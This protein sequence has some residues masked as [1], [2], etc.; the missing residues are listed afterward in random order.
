MISSGVTDCTLFLI[1]DE[2]A[3]LDLLETILEDDGYHAIVRTADARQAIPVFESSAPDLVLLDLH[4]PHRSGFEV[5]RDICERTPPGDYLPVLVLTADV[6][7]QAKERALSGGARDFLTKPFDAGE[8][9]LRVRNLLQTRLL[10]RQQ[11]E[12]REAAEAM[13]AEN[14]LLFAQAQ[15][16]TRARER[17]LSVVAHDLRNPLA[18]VTMYV[19]ML[20]S[21]LPPGE[22]PYRRDALASIFD[23]TQRMQ[24]LIEDLL[25]SARVQEGT[26]ALDREE[27]PVG[28]LLEE[29]ER[30]LRPLAEASAIEL[31]F[32]AD[33][34]PL[35]QAVSLDGA[36]LLQV[37]SNLVGNALKFTP[38]G[39][40]VTVSW[41]LAEGE[42][43]VSV[44]DTGPGIAAEQLP[45]LFG[46][47][48]Q[49]GE[50][51]RRGLGLGLWISRAIVE[52][53]GGRIWVDSREGEGAVFH[54]TLPAAGAGATEELPRAVMAALPAAAWVG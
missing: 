1:D 45:H 53:H 6:T 18:V 31:T 48:W 2:E 11:R 54:F 41:A 14:A 27:Q 9:S 4:M 51:D 7:P 28:R 25:D 38:E 21:M 29:A 30:M 10:Q 34:V 5:L 26:F 42:L 13:A 40:R 19:E 17:M 43:R 47:F 37:I 20:L 12:A 23:S 52:A 8:V 44:A 49:A 16:A 46:A 3:N 39:G 22:D 24:Q 32:R 50:A 36:R 35:A 15:D 33:G